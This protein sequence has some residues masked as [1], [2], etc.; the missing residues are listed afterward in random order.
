MR[1]LTLRQG[2]GHVDSQKLLL[3]LLND[4]AFSSVMSYLVHREKGQPS[5]VVEGW[6]KDKRTED[7]D[8]EDS[9]L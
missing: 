2:G 1:S 3:S 6:G 7:L 9:H 4:R 5:V 8:P